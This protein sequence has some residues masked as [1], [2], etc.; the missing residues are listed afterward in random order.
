MHEGLTHETLVH[1]VYI[2]VSCSCTKLY[3]QEKLI[4]YAYDIVN[5]KMD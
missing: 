4:T 3:H 5:Q 2:T 1:A